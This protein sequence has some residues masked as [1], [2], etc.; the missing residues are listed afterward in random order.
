MRVVVM[1]DYNDTRELIVTLLRLVRIDV[2]ATANGLEGIELVRRWLPDVALVD[3]RMPGA[4]A[5]EVAA[6]LRAAPATHGIP[7]ILVKTITDAAGCEHL[8]DAV[9][10]QP[11]DFGTLYGALLPYTPSDMQDSLRRWHMP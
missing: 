11:F 6:T 4:H 2:H 10:Q 3:H 7:L 8:F 1:D 5:D 9:I